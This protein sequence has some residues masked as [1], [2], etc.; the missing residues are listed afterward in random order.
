MHA[1]VDH[2]GTAK[3]TIDGWNAK[4]GAPMTAALTGQVAGNHLDAEG[5]WANGVRID[6]HWTRAP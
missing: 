2:A 3:L 1:T 5:R 4:S 6:G